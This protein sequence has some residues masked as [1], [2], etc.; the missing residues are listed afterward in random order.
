VADLLDRPVGELFREAARGAENEGVG[1]RGGRGP[2][3]RGAASVPAR[4][5]RAGEDAAAEILSAAFALLIR[6][7]VP[8]MRRIGMPALAAALREERPGAAV[9]GLLADVATESLVADAAG[10]PLAQAVAASARRRR[11]LLRE[12]GGGLSTAAVAALLGTSR[13]AVDKRRRAGTLLAVPL[14]TKDWAFPTAQ[15]GPEGRPL[16]GLAEALRAFTIDDPWMRLAE[17][18]APDEDLGGRSVLKVLA[19]E[20]R[21]ALPAVCR[22]L[23]GVGEHGA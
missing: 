14:P 12:A 23:A 1:A 17:M 19:E 8:F 2:A 3:Q 16:D 22:A 10:D 13:Q 21:E 18:L 5:A 4:G 7:A 9:A 15:F 6:E 20:G 11:E